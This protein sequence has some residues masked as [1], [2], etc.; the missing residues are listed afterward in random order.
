MNTAHCPPPTAHYTLHTAQGTPSSGSASTIRCNTLL[1]AVQGGFCSLHIDGDVLYLN[2]FV[3]KCVKVNQARKKK[4]FVDKY[5]SCFVC[6]LVLY[7]FIRLY[8]LRILMILVITW[9]PTR[10]YG[11]N[12]QMLGR[13]SFSARDIFLL[14]FRVASLFGSEIGLKYVLFQK[15]KLIGR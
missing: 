15:K 3:S 8:F 11:N 5:S 12:V 9:E 13:S 1:H 14:L 6:K 4:N 10:L 7:F 2:I